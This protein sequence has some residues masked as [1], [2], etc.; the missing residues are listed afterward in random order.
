MGRRKIEIKMV[1]DANTRQ[2]TF[3]KR[4][5]GL[6]K[7]ANELSILCGSE[8]AIVVFSPGSKPYS[9]GHPGVDA[10]AAKFL[11]QDP[12]PDAAAAGDGDG[13]GEGGAHMET[14]NLVFKEVAEQVREEE[15]EGAAREE[16]VEQL[17]KVMVGGGE[18]RS[19]LQELN[20]KHDGFKLIV[21][22]RLG[23]L[24]AVE[25]ML[26]LAEKPV[27][28]IGNPAPKKKRRTN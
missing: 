12:K 22:E 11:N 17:R 20:A 4:R 23:M 26:L 27:V 28:G 1:K 24:E 6:F 8:V 9:F 3:S 15:K 19:E 10:V 25:S 16:A 18:G 5:T 7:K 2:V 13:E 14:L 21:R